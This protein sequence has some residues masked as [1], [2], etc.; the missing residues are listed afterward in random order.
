MEALQRHHLVG[1]TPGAAT[2]PSQAN[3]HNSHH[4]LLGGTGSGGGGSNHRSR[5]A[6]TS[7]AEDEDEDRGMDSTEECDLD[8]K[9][10]RPPRAKKKEQRQ[11]QQDG[12]KEVREI[13]GTLSEPLYEEDIIEGFSFAAFKTYED[14]EV[15]R[16]TLWGRRGRRGS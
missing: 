4:R 6:T 14:L 3:N 7:E 1:V 8:L 12:G 5:S 10:L 11:Q 2:A 9:P 16:K 13:D 15:R